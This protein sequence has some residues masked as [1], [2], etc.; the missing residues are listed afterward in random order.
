MVQIRDECGDGLL[1]V[2]IVF[3]QRIICIEQQCLSTSEPGRKTHRMFKDNKEDLWT[4]VFVRYVPASIFSIEHRHQEKRMISTV[5][6]NS[7]A[8][9]PI[10][11]KAQRAIKMLRARIRLKDVEPQPVCFEF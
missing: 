7:L 9:N 11:L 4:A 3:P 8:E 2:N 1:E 5:T 6:I 10:L